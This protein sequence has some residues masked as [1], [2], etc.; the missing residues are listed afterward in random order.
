M[1]PISCVHTA[2][3]LQLQGG[4]NICRLSSC[5]STAPCCA[6]LHGRS[7]LTAGRLLPACI[8]CNGS[9]T[10]LPCCVTLSHAGLHRCSGLAAAVCP[11]G[12]LLPA[13]IACNCTNSSIPHVV[14]ACVICR[15]GFTGAQASPLQCAALADS[16]WLAMLA[17]APTLLY[18]VVSRSYVQGFTGAQASPV[19]DFLL[20][21]IACT[22]T[23]L[24]FC[25]TLNN[26]ACCATLSHAGLHGCPGLAAAVCRTGRL[27]L[28]CI[29]CT[30]TC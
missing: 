27:L 24:R 3:S 6:R 17:I 21:C 26:M 5:L 16:C 19:A 22:N 4:R 28:A 25:V 12:R 14:S 10:S 23:L 8:A 20:A 9:N 30:N 15:K 2:A 11:A 13:C 7:G 1:F 18:L 29:A